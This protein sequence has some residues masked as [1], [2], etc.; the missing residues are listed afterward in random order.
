MSPLPFA[1]EMPFFGLKGAS[2]RRSLLLGLLAIVGLA[3]GHAQTPHSQA[4]FHF[5]VI[6]EVM[7]SYGGDA[8]VQFVEIRMLTSGQ[9]LVMNS[10]LGAFDAS[11]SYLGDVLIVPGNVASSGVGVRWIMGTSAFAT[12]SGLTPDFTMPGMGGVSLPTTGGMVCWGA[13]GVSPPAPG[14]WVHTN[15]SNYVDCL[16]YGS[17]SGPTNVHIGTPTSLDAIGH[18]LQRVAE[19]DN[20]A[21]DFVCADPATPKKNNGTTVSMA[22][23]TPCGLPP[24]DADGDGV[25]DS[26]D[27][28]PNWPNPAQNLPPYPI[29]PGDPDCDGWATNDE[30]FLPTD[31]SVACHNS[32]GLPDWPPDMDDSKMIN[33]SD[34]VPFKP[35]FGATDP[36]DPI[37][38]TRYDLN[39]SGSI[40]ISDLVPFKPFFGMSCA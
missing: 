26:S 24:G 31:P 38:D 15:P 22:A 3:A 23:T 25:P 9:N 33:I 10:V 34:L 21:N 4:V 12:A 29:P 16:A 30:D 20:N 1:G 5:A 8:N 2:M 18:S 40:N 35:H 37:Y 11:G 6:D 14:S 32:T 7:T 27:N 13:P 28:C 36:S 17:Y 39:M 19:T